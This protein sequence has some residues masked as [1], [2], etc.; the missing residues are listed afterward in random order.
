MPDTTGPLLTLLQ[1]L[2]NR[3]FAM[4]SQLM[5]MKPITHQAI[6]VLSQLSL[7]KSDQNMNEAPQM[8]EILAKFSKSASSL[9]GGLLQNVLEDA[10][11]ERARSNTIHSHTVDL[12]DSNH[13]FLKTRPPP[14]R[15]L[16]ATRFSAP[17]AAGLGTLQQMEEKEFPERDGELQTKSPLDQGK[18][19]AGASRTSTGV[20]STMKRSK[21]AGHT[22]GARAFSS[23]TEVAP[24]MPPLPAP[25]I[26]RAPSLVVT[27]AKD[28][29]QSSSVSIEVPM[30]FD[31][32]HPSV[33]TAV[34]PRNNQSV[35]S[36][37][38]VSEKSDS[39]VESESISRPGVSTPVAFSSRRTS[40]FREA[41]A[42]LERQ[43]NKRI[44]A[45]YENAFSAK[46]NQG[47]SLA[48]L[49]ISIP[50]VS[51]IN[52]EKA[53]EEK[54]AQVVEQPP[55]TS[56]WITGLNPLSSI[57]VNFEVFMAVLYLIPLEVG[58]Q[59]RLHWGYSLMLSTIFTF[60]IAVEF[61]TFRK[62][63]PAM[64][65][66]DKPCLRDWQ[67]YYLKTG[68]CL[69]L[70]S[71]LPF[72]VLP[73]REQEFLWGLR[74]LRLYKLPRIFS[75]S[76]KFAAIRKTLESSL[77]IGKTFSGIFSLLFCLAIFLHL[78][79]C[80]LFLAGR[81]NDFSNASIANVQ[82]K[83]TFERYIWALFTA[84]GN[85]FPLYYKP[86][87]IIEQMIVIGFLLVGAGLY[88]SIVGMI[89]AFSMGFDASGRLYKQKMDELREYFR[90]KDINEI[91]QRK[92][93][94]YYEIK[95]RGKFFEEEI[96][97]SD[98]NEPLRKEI[99]LHNCKS[100]ISKVNFLRRDMGDGRDDLFLGRIAMSLKTCYFV[101][102]DI[103]ISEGGVDSDMYFIMSGHVNVFVSG[104][105]VTTLS[106]GSF[107]G[108][109][110]LLRNNVCFSP[111]HNH[112]A[113]VALMG[114]LSRTSTVQAVSSCMLYRL[115]KRNFADI[116]TEYPDMK[117]KVE[118]IFS[119]TLAKL[120]IAAGC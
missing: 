115:S 118:I 80:I 40:L 75:T 32:E 63:H 92:I 98:L 18:S 116:L 88:A 83:D 62:N 101:T 43:A 119:K 48:S 94:K 56:M 22:A 102:G 103:I 105:N 78:E 77:G 93:F 30:I 96:L 46:Y 95:Y 68:F 53:E 90:W 70:M 76:P 20:C 86:N 50:P 37:K 58:L 31:A 1:E 17:V 13:L 47:G 61:A 67:L 73:V 52:S 45:F 97:F 26:L 2:Q 72:E 117:E 51:E 81:L 91:T 85:T 120:R 99:A 110:A 113:E 3:V 4:E 39:T 111:P 49:E 109:S 28:L 5:I 14:G 27:E 44:S 12:P 112:H 21:S 84:T 89:S 8:Q 29:R 11:P 64:S 35:K 54:A 33:V 114:N 15:R 108:D 42:T 34:Q 69:D 79:A 10:T 23:T 36:L 24:A 107:F 106:E 16:S 60:D 59:L 25:E 82:F 57:S 7:N 19:A 6:L 74:L 104:K 9:K 66:L 41:S 71:A 55:S 87:S 100:I 65:V 38:N